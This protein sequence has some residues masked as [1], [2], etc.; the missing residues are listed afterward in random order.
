VL[1]KVVYVLTC[2]ILGLIVVLFRPGTQDERDLRAPRRS[3]PA[4]R[5]HR[6]STPLQH[7]QGIAQRV[8]ANKRDAPSAMVTDAGKQQI[9][10]R[11]VLSGLINKYTH[12][13]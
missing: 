9:R 13:A 11:P 8:P 7:R 6:I 2:R 3:A 10:R 1:L 12:A 4:S 5:P